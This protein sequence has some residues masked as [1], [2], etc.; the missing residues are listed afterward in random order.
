M[1]V[2]YNKY[3]DRTATG[4]EE[5][6]NQVVTY[7]PE[8]KGPECQLTTS[9]EKKIMQLKTLTELAPLI[10]SSL[11][12][13]LIRKKTIEATTWVLNAEAASLFLLDKATGELYIDVATGEKGEKL[14][15]VR[16]EKGVG[17]AGHVVEHGE[18]LIIHDAQSDT[19]FFEGVDKASGFTT[20][21]IICVPVKSREQTIGVL[22]GINKKEGQFDDNDIEVMDSISNYV[23]VAIENASLHNE[24]KKTFYETAEVMADTIELRDP[25]TGGHTKRVRRH[26]LVIG[27]YMG[28]SKGELENLHLA[29]ILHDIGKIGIKDDIL[30]K[31]G[32]LEEAE[33]I[34][35]RMHSL[36]GA[37]LLKNIEQL[38][39]VI[40]CIRAHHERYDGT[41]YPDGLKNDE[42]PLIARIITVADTFDAMTSERPYRRRLS[43]EAALAELKRFAGIQFDP[44]VIEAFLEAFKEGNLSL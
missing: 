6:H 17:I 10:N 16:L 19:R 8:K 38:R 31:D 13:E 12:H 23:A 32:K 42:I 24:L 14:E 21:N 40:P 36:Y 2:R 22:E 44:E 35:M 20:R 18:A 29:A 4:D 25:Y 7:K 3:S 41:G 15:R 33:F 5:P 30:L 27:R 43:K 28:L 1:T 34:K 9:L 39:D 37:E 11:D 26:C